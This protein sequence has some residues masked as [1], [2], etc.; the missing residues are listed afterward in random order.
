MYRFIRSPTIVNAGH[1]NGN[2]LFNIQNTNTMKKYKMPSDIL[3]IY[4]GP[5]NKKPIT[6]PN[7]SP[8]S[9][10]KPSPKSPP[11]PPRKSPSKSITSYK[12]YKPHKPYHGDNIEEY[13]NAYCI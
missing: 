1:K 11:K 3:N 5:R 10:S 7:P 9:P 4:A 8:K 2:F 13:Y 6:K 12:P